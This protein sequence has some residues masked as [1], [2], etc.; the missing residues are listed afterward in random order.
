MYVTSVGT[1]LT[2]PVARFDG[3]GKGSS[4]TSRTCSIVPEGEPVTFWSRSSNK[5]LTVFEGLRECK[6]YLAL[7]DKVISIVWIRLS[8]ADSSWS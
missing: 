7:F 1:P 3:A 2:C 8:L 5:G 4:L 6:V